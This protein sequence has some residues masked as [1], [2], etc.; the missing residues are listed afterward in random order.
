MTVKARPASAF[1]MAQAE[2]TFE[3]FVITFDA[4]ARSATIGVCGE[5]RV[6]GK[7]E[8]QYFAGAASPFGHSAS[9]HSTG[10]G[11]VRLSSRAAGCTRTAA[12]RE[13][14]GAFDPSRQGN[15][16]ACLFA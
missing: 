7:V 16:A 11:V 9:R 4:P 3:L 1:V 12:K 2:F 8:S 14:S 5:G 10:C 15:A 6:P 13:A